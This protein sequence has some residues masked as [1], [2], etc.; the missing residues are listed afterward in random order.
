MTE[1]EKMLN[2]LLFDPTDPEL[3][4][5]RKKAVRLTIKFNN[6]DPD[7]KQEE[8]KIL[9]ELFKQYDESSLVNRPL[10]VDYG[11]NISIGAHTIIN[12]DC[13]FLDTHCINIGNHVLIAPD[14]KIYTAYHP[15]EY[16]DR[17]KIKTDGSHFVTTLGAPVNISDYT[18]IGGGTVILPGVNIGRNVIIGAG[19]VVTKSI[20]D[21]CI[22]Y[23]NP[24]RVVKK[25]K[26]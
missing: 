12:M 3:K 5:I 11:N 25:I 9:K 18:W 13:T 19:S 15:I 21:N 7:D 23:G 10:Y 1:R 26:S 22:A 17:H 2:G 4:G 6:S 20:H 16:K 14:V 8:N 24:C